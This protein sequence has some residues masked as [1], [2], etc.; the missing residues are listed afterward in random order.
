MTI[1]GAIILAALILWFAFERLCKMLYEL[2]AAENQMTD[3]V[4]GELNGNI[5]ELTETMK[6]NKRL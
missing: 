4:F 1:A 2:K 3:R 5:I 6:K